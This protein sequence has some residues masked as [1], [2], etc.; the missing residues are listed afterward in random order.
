MLCYFYNIVNFYIMS[1]LKIELIDI[2]IEFKEINKS[3]FDSQYYNVDDKIIISPDKKGFISHEL[4]PE[5]EKG[6]D[7]KNTVVINAGVGQGKSRAILEMAKK[8][9]NSNDYIVIIAVPYKNLIEQYV[10]DCLKFTDRNKIFNLL[11]IEKEKIQ[12]VFEVSDEDLADST[13]SIS[14]FKIHVMTTNGLLGNPGDDSLFQAGIK[15]K[16]FE[17]LQR[18]FDKKGK[19]IVIIFDEIHDSIHNFREELI[20]NL[21]NYQGL[22]H[23]IFTVSATYNEA[24]KE[25]IKY[26][27]EL[28]DKKIQIIEAKRNLIKEKQSELLVNF[29]TDKNIERDKKLI[30]LLE[31]L[32][33]EE[34]SFDMVVYSS[35]LVKKF[36]SKP[37]K[38][39]KYRS[40]NNLLYA[41]NVNKCYNDDFDFTAKKSYNSSMVNIGTNFTTGVNIEK[42][43][44][45]FIIILPKKVMLEYFNNKGVF[46]NG[47][48]TVIQTLAR[49]RKKGRIHIFMPLPLSLEENSLKYEVNISKMILSNFNSL[50]IKSSEKVGYSYIN[51]QGKILDQVY[52][53]LF[54]RVRNSVEK[55]DK[56]N[57][58]GMNPL[59]YP[60]KEI[61]KLYKGEKYL[62]EN[63]FGGNISTYI[64]WASMCNQF[65]NCRLSDIHISRKIYLTSKDIE[66]EIFEIYISH[67]DFLN[68]SEEYY[69]F[70]NSFSA[71]E[72]WEYFRTEF[73]VINEVLVDDNQLTQT[74]KDKIN[75]VLFKLIFENDIDADKTKVY[76]NYLKSSIYFSKE[77]ELFICEYFKVSEENLELVNFFKEWN[78][79]VELL[80]SKKVKKKENIVLPSEV[81]LEFQQLFNDKKMID[82]LKEMMGKDLII[83]NKN[84]PIHDR[85]RKCETDKQFTNSFYRLLIEVLY[86]SPKYKV[87][88]VDKKNTGFYVLNNGNV[89]DFEMKNILYKQKAEYYL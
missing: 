26:L 52:K 40:V 80:E 8:Y 33:K 81:F 63:F 42:I 11:E 5:L 24:S 68:S 9:S 29:Y 10:K 18:Y 4:L 44:H 84:F 14:R 82:I 43:N 17:D 25:V 66:N 60:K 38:D 74:Y 46:T 65:L 62:A 53:N 23:K 27:S 77:I 86:N 15:R 12:N 30:S 76:L 16:Y 73:F 28:T 21:W 37:S 79:F 34:K 69:A 32:L 89:D 61:F 58:Q 54:Y 31:N 87:F 55:I 35:S 45:D 41:V 6:F 47:A 75:L 51:E 49:Q 22:V 88:K 39:Q 72:K 50:G 67:R 19:K 56:A 71:F 48:N 3:D 7:V 2:P 78:S 57:R 20:I 64:L 1:A 85:F 83:S 70:F 13:F 59:Q 36:I